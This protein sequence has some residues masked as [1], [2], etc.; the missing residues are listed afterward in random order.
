MEIITIFV[1]FVIGFIAAFL[2]GIAGG[3]GGLLSI[4]ALTILGL[5]SN[6]AIA[7]NRFGIIGFSISSIYQFYKAKK[8]IFTY[9]IPFVIVS[10]IGSIIGA[11][12]LIEFN[13]EVLSK[14]IGFLIIFLLPLT[15]LKKDIGLKRRFLPTSYKILG[16]LGYFGIAI[17]DGF[18]GAGAGIIATY[19]FVFLLGVTYIEANALDKVAYILNAIISTIIF[20]VY[21]LINYTFGI[22]LLI[23]MLLGGYFGAHSAIKKGNKFVRIAFVVLVI[24]SAV[25]LIFF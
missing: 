5:P 17:Y 19:L 1:V 10:T 21:G 15:F 20:A 3:G 9:V 8:I 13:E 14:L 12:M 4:P 24:V 11:K 25:K 16:I 7:T 2:G 22:I 23:G 18:F 6:V